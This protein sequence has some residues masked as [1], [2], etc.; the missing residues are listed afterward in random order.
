MYDAAACK[1]AGCKGHGPY[2]ILGFA[3]F[4]V[5]GYSFNGSANDGTLGKKCPDESRG[6]YCIQGDF[7]KFTTSQGAPG[8]GTNFGTSLI[9][10]YS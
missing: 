10:L 5:T 1:A 8:P 7:I 6:K 9:Y 4:H 2:P 3:M